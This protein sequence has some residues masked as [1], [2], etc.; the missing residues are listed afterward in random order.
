MYLKKASYESVKARFLAL[1][2]DE[3]ALPS[4]P[5]LTVRLRRAESGDQDLMT[6]MEIIK[7]RVRAA[8]PI[9]EAGPI[10]DWN[11]LKADLANREAKL[12]A[13][14]RDK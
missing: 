1:D 7:A 8:D 10:R 13:P 9:H 6:R 5:S 3:R 11:K 4:P 2:A 12:P 14:A